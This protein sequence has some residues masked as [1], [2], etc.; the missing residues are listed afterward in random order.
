MINPNWIKNVLTFIVGWILSLLLWRL[1]R[2]DFFASYLN[3]LNIPF[4]IVNFLLSIVFVSIIAGLSFGSV[5]HYRDYSRKRKSSFKLL[6]FKAIT[7]HL[8]IMLCLYAITFIVIKYSKLIPDFSFSDFLQNPIIISNFIYALIINSLIVIIIY[9]NKL[10]GKGILFKLVTGQFY[11]PK[12]EFRAFMF[13][14]LQSSTEIAETLGHI[15]YSNF[16]QDCFYDLSI[17]EKTRADIYQYVGDEVVLTWKANNNKILEDCLNSF[18]LFRERLQSNE[19]YYLTKYNI[20]PV[21]TA[22][23]H[24]GN[25]T[26]AE[27]GSFKREI[28]Y[29]GDTINIASRIQN[30]CKT[31]NKEFLISEDFFECVKDSSFFSFEKLQETILRGRKNATLLF[32]VS[33]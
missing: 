16:I 20:K 30:Q 33:K 8:I 25:I 17:L 23:M 27:V 31:L 12:E 24:I 2:V 21:F 7:I 28:A 11:S 19:V 29:H 4:S 26:V 15:K 10:F 5:Q 32:A 22:G 1:I 6:F 3:A 13:L 9:L 18:F 14:D